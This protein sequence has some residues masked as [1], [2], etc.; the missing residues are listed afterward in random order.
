RRSRAAR[1]CCRSPHGPGT[2]RTSRRGDAVAGADAGERLVA[3]LERRPAQR[4]RRHRR[5]ETGLFL[6]AREH[7]LERRAEVEREGVAARLALPGTL[8]LRRLEVGAPVV[9]QHDTVAAQ[10]LL[11][12]DEPEGDVADDR[13]DG[14]VEA[15]LPAAAARRP[16]DQHVAGPDLDLVALRRQPLLRAVGPAQDLLRPAAGLAA[17]HAPRPGQPAVVVDRDLAR[18]EVDVPLLDAVAAAMET[19]AA[20]VG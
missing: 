11:A 20:R 12:R 15:V 14:P 18:L 1:A 16:V 10:R 5:V 2:P 3:G 4:L 9:L 17:E 7:L 8:L 6:A 19:G 13:L